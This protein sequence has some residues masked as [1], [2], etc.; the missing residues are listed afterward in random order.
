M[1]RA[2]AVRPGEGAE[3]GE[4]R[5]REDDGEHAEGR[6]HARAVDEQ[7]DGR[8]DD[9]EGQAEEQRGQRQHARAILA[10]RVFLHDAGEDRGLQ[11]ADR[12][13]A[14][15][16][17]EPPGRGARGEAH[18]AERHEE[19]AAEERRAHAEGADH[20]G[21]RERHQGEPG[22][23]ARPEGAEPRRGHAAGLRGGLDQPDHDEGRQPERHAER[24]RGLQ[25]P[26][27]PQGEA[28]DVQGA[29]EVRAVRA[30]A[31]SP[32]DLAQRPHDSRREQGDG[33]LEPEG[34]AGRERVEPAAD[35]R[36]ARLADLGGGP[37]PA[38]PAR[39]LGLPARRP[40][41]TPTAGRG[42]RRR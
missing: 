28:H 24:H 37:H 13:E 20:P 4:R 33:H 21:A 11:P 35:G 32:R 40:R 3:R 5:G 39:V 1:T 22:V 23:R 18:V 29:R 9:H 16:E 12:H 17:A 36:A 25:P 6:R 7:A 31:V 14:E 30:G 2:A 19:A 8:A 38:V 41:A 26:V 34:Q 10:R 27:M 15:V 42:R